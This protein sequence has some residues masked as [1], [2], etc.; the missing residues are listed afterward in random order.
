MT[1]LELTKWYFTLK[2]VQSLKSLPRIK[3]ALKNFNKTFGDSV[4]SEI[5]PFQLEEYQINRLDYGMSKASVDMEIKI[6]QTVI[7]KGLDNEK[8]SNENILRTFRKIKRKLRPNS[9]A[10]E[11]ILSQEEFESLMTFLP[12][13]LK[14]IVATGYYTGMRFTEIAEMEWGRFNLKGRY[15][16]LEDK[17]T[18]TDEKRVLPICDD[19]HYYLKDIPQSIHTDFVFLFRIKPI[20]DILTALRKACESAN[21][22]YGRDVK[23]G[24]VFHDLRHTFNTNMRKAS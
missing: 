3:G 18:K 22:P 10:R 15:F 19:L 14:R 20:K 11:R 8:I 21:I 9:N 12:I 6:A 1:F 13:H 5:Q 7:N 4:I 2:S 17:H 24:F 16:E 23:N